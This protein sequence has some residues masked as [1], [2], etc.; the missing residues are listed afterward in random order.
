MLIPIPSITILLSIEHIKAAEFQLGQ[1]PIPIKH[2]AKRALRSSRIRLGN[3]S[4][5][6]IFGEEN[7]FSI[8]NRRRKLIKRRRRDK[9]MWLTRGK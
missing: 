3:L 7:M 9:S 6:R 5:F 8:V 1:L 2:L 4:R